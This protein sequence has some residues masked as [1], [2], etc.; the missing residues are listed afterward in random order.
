MMPAKDLYH[1][2]CVNAL[3]KDGWTITHD[4]LTL[5]VEETKLQIDIGAERVV[6]AERNGERI[7]VEIKSFVS[8]SAIQDLK[9]AVGQ[10]WLYDLALKQSSAESDRGLYLAVRKTVYDE[11]FVES[12][13]KLFLNNHSLRLIVF[14][15][16]KEEIILWIK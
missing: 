12:I 10:F 7:A 14:D 5:T 4:P 1:V 9:E 13:G 15:P 3:Q 8:L 2:A 16:D 6:A 11:V